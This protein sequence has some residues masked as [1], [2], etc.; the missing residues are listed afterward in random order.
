[1]NRGP[2]AALAAALAVVLAVVAA[3]VSGCGGDPEGDPSDVVQQVVDARTAGDCE[4]YEDL[5]V[6]DPLPRC[7]D[8]RPEVAG[9]PEVGEADVDG[10]EATVEV[11]DHYD[12][13]GFG[14][15]DVEYVDTYHLRV[16]DD[17]WKVDEVEFSETTS[18]DCLSW[19][20]GL[21][22]FEQ[23]FDHEV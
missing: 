2:L 23:V 11:V 13:S 1:M 18:D 16:D 5:F 22:L 19:T 20:P 14:E 17:A 9:G 8:P 3:L 7:S 12:C 21:D 4:G 15:T 6:G 10:E